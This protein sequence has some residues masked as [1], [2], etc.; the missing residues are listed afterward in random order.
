M[1][2][3]AAACLLSKNNISSKPLAAC[4]EVRGFHQV[5]ALCA[6]SMHGPGGQPSGTPVLD[7]SLKKQPTR[8]D[9]P[10]KGHQVVQDTPASQGSKTDDNSTTSG[11]ASQGN[12]PAD[13][14]RV[15]DAADRKGFHT[16]RSVPIT[17]ITH[18]RG[19]SAVQSVKHAYNDMSGNFALSDRHDPSRDTAAAAEAQNAEK[20]VA[21]GSTRKDASD[22]GRPSESAPTASESVNQNVRDKGLHGAVKDTQGNLQSTKNQQVVQ[23]TSGAARSLHTAA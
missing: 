2:R 15:T 17:G 1:I 8:D 7:K 13:A 4:F 23:D 19:F 9:A 20:G 18:T 14:T 12:S 3:R 11:S 10:S 6:P 5:S 21:S 22:T 16:L